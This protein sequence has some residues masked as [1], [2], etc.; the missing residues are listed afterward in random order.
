MKIRKLHERDWKYL[1]SWEGVADR[2][3]LPLNGTGGFVVESQ[4]D[5]TPVAV[6]WLTLKGETGTLSEIISNKD[7]KDNDKDYAIQLLEKFSI[8]FV[9]T[10]EYELIKQ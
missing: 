3:A 9:A 1:D 6:Q 7:Y 2:E 8:D 5:R 4:P 10:M